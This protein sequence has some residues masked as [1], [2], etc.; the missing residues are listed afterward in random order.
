MFPPFS[1][2]HTFV[3]TAHT[4]LATQTA[5]PLLSPQNWGHLL[6]LSNG[7]SPWNERL[8]PTFQSAS[9]MHSSRGGAEN[10]TEETTGQRVTTGLSEQGQILRCKTCGGLPLCPLQVGKGHSHKP[11]QGAMLKLGFSEAHT[12]AFLHNCFDREWLRGEADVMQQHLL[13]WPSTVGQGI[14]YN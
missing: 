8:P 12:S 3:G 6:A 13:P 2:I 14:H 4:C 11:V 10:Y 1:Q 5:S 9:G 7:L